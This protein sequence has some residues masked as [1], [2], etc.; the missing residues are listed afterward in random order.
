MR[1]VLLTNARNN[2]PN[3]NRLDGN[4]LRWI[5]RLG[6]V[7]WGLIEVAVPHSI[8]NRLFSHWLKLLYLFEIV[9]LFG[10]ILFGSEETLRLALTLFGVT[11]AI[12]ITMLL[13]RDMMRLK[14]RWLR[15]FIALFVGAILF[16]AGIGADELFNLKVRERLVARTQ[17]IRN[18]FR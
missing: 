18:R 4:H 3:S 15:F 14:Y 2:A 16:L 9:L 8:L 5:A 17:N 7:F 6:Q 13:L 11:A 12:N 1:R 10:A